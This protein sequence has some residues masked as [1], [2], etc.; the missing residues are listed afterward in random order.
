V[1]VGEDGVEGEV[2]TY[3]E[4]SPGNGVFAALVDDVPRVV[5]AVPRYTD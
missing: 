5:E 1:F 2:A 3:E 4:A